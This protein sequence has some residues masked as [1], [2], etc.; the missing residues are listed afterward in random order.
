MTRSILVAWLFVIV[1]IGF[2]IQETVESQSYS[3]A[4]GG[5]PDNFTGDYKL[6]MTVRINIP[7]QNVLSVDQDTIRVCPNTMLEITVVPTIQVMN[8]RGRI[9]SNIN[10]PPSTPTCSNS[11]SGSISNGNDILLNGFCGEFRYG[12]A[13]MPQTTTVAMDGTVRIRSANIRIFDQT[14]N[15]NS[16]FART[17]SVNSELNLNNQIA[18][19]VT[20]IGGRITIISTNY[21]AAWCMNSNISCYNTNSNLVFNRNVRFIPLSQSEINNVININVN[22][23]SINTNGSQDIELVIT[24]LGNREITIT[25]LSSNLP[26]VSVTSGLN[27]NIQSGQSGRLNVRFSNSCQSQMEGQITIQYRSSEPVCGQTVQKSMNIPVRCSALP[28]LVPSGQNNSYSSGTLG[29][30]LNVS[31]IG[32]GSA[33]NIRVDVRNN[34]TNT[35]QSFNYPGTLGPNQIWSIPY[36]V[37]CSPGERVRI[38][39]SVDPQNS[40]VE[41]NENNNNQIYDL[42]CGANMCELNPSS[43]SIQKV[44]G[45]TAQT[46]IR[47]GGSS[48][49]SVS[50]TN[51]PSNY[52]LFQNSNPILTFVLQNPNAAPNQINLDITATANNNQYECRFRIDISGSSSMDDCRKRI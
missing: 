3:F 39:V 6:S 26:G 2:Q 50:I 22:P 34:K 16:V 24:N 18:Y 12:P 17:I 7:P 52:L 49:S 15:S 51:L 23:S 29:V 27:Q 40:I 45:A 11:V 42:M 44:Q 20:Q 28:D 43:A 31:N 19:S 47:C 1:S 35:W 46:E 38:E 36:S 48:C 4:L 5:S 30:T 14:H 13:N 8:P 37:Q 21:T 33:S 25:S 32:S 10:N 41:S 9:V